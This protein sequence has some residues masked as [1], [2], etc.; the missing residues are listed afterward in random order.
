MW[1]GPFCGFY[2]KGEQAGL[3]D[4]RFGGTGTVPSGLVPGAG[5]VGW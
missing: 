3:N 2:G 4:A 1:A 5:V